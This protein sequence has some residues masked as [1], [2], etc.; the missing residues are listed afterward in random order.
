MVRRTVVDIVH[1]GLFCTWLIFGAAAFAPLLEQR[2]FAQNV[3]IPADI[4]QNLCKAP[5]I[6]GSGCPAAGNGC[7]GCTGSG[8]SC[9][10]AQP[11]DTCT[12]GVGGCGGTGGC[13]CNS[14]SC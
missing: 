14:N 6:P 13:V 12:D 7:A 10:S 11:D 1:Q 3:I 2:A 9:Q 5:T 4:T 8:W